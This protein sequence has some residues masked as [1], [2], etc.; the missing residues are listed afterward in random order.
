MKPTSIETKDTFI[1]DLDLCYK[2]SANIKRGPLIIQTITDTALN[3]DKRLQEPIGTKLET[4]IPFA[5][6]IFSKLF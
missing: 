2:L 3:T 6:P 1:N 5:Q 4:L